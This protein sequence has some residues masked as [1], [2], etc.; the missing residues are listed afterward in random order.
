MKLAF[1]TLGCPAWDLDRILEAATRWRFDGV[2]I[3]GILD[4]LD[5]PNSTHFEPGTRRETKRRFD[6]LGIEIACI[7][8]STHLCCSDPEDRMQQIEDGRA[9][10]A[11]A[12]DVG[13]PLVRVFGGRIPKGVS[14]TE[15][16]KRAADVLA[17]LGNFALGHGVTVV[18][19]THDDFIA[20]LDVAAVL[21]L[22]NSSGAAAL[23]DVN[24]P[25][26][27]KG[28]S[29]ETTV[30]SL[31]GSIKHVHVK[32]SIAGQKG[33]TLVGEGELPLKEIVRLLNHA[34][35]KGY[36]SF[37]WEKRWN[38]TIQEPE[39]AFPH[40]ADTMRKLLAEVE[41]A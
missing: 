37:E 10:V 27:M 5:L 38:P 2:E 28:E 1:S 16:N 8:C 15:G 13:S 18:L 24:H 19:E 20:S 31:R 30:Q 25:Y 34:R 6:D 36:L 32:D 21:K 7:S 23:W 9:N 41:D 4:E 22:A 33:H 40:Y 11:L 3:R 29:P 17:E 35:Y 39:I 12:A 14:R 26:R